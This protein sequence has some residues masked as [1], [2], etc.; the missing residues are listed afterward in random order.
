L[1][2]QKL[3]ELIK[4]DEDELLELEKEEA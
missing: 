1:E 4:A 2:L 3:E